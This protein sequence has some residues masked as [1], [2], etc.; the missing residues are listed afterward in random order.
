LT[1]RNPRTPRLWTVTVHV[2]TVVTVK[3]CTRGEARSAGNAVVTKAYVAAD[4][5][6]TALSR[7]SRKNATAVLGDRYEG[8]DVGEVD[9]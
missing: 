6:I 3:A 7:H 4:K 8:A 9:E 2:P 5:A 1:A